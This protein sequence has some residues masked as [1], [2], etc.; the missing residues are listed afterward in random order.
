MNRTGFNVIFVLSLIVQLIASALYYLSEFHGGRRY[1]DGT[2]RRQW[3]N[4]LA[5]SSG[6]LSH[7]GRDNWPEPTPF[8]PAWRGDECFDGHIELFVASWFRIRET[9]YAGGEE[10]RQL[11]VAERQRLP[12]FY[13][14]RKG[15]DVYFGRIAMVATVPVVLWLFVNRRLLGRSRPREG[16]CVICGYDLRASPHRCPECGTTE[17]KAVSQSRQR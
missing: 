5:L 9:W 10:N 11:S 8:A 16:T 6:Q 3:T 7:R 14:Y 2:D 1:W 13:Y 15:F 12:H 4:E 17:S